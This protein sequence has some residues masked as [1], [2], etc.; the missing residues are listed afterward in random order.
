MLETVFGALW[1]IITLPI[2]LVVW[3]VELLGR[4][5]GLGL[6]FVMMVVGVALLAGPLFII[7]I[8]VFIVGLLLT[9]RSL[10]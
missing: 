6:G 2:R 7:G 8:P 10:G 1:S 9:L 5:V 4:V 3:V